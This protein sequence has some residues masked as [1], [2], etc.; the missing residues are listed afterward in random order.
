MA[1][2]SPARCHENGT[3]RRIDRRFMHLT[4]EP[5]ARPGTTGYRILRG[6]MADA[7]IEVGITAQSTLDDDPRHLLLRRAERVRGSRHVCAGRNGGS[8]RAWLGLLAAVHHPRAKREERQ[9]NALRIGPLGARRAGIRPVVALCGVLIAAGF[10]TAGL[11]AARTERPA[12]ATSS[13]LPGR[14]A[15]IRPRAA[16]TASICTTTSTTAAAAGSSRAAPSPWPTG[17]STTS[18]H[19]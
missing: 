9:M 14:P 4:W 11:T 8:H 1:R 13:S 2:Q 15:P 19:R 5:V 6:I 3:R 7:L 16:A 10:L 18:R 17:T 12:P